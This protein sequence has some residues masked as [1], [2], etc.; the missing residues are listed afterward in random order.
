MAPA[1]PDPTTT[2]SKL[3]PA[4][5]ALS[6]WPSVPEKVRPPARLIASTACPRNDRRGTAN[7]LVLLWRGGWPCAMMVCAAGREAKR[8]L[9]AVMEIVESRKTKMSEKAFVA[10]AKLEDVP[11]GG[12]KVVEING[13]SVILV[14]TKDKIFAVRNLCSHAYETME[15]GREIG[16]A[17]V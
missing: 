12:K 4:V 13:V 16:R 7:C 5:T 17:H 8:R 9:P 6:P 15:C 10:A 3:S 2:T 14:N 1:A 11:A